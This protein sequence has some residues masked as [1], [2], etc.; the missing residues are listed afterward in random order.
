MTGFDWIQDSLNK[1][2]EQSIWYFNQRY[3]KDKR[4]QKTDFE[5]K[6]D[7]LFWSI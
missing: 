1:A 4:L 2:I 3:G 5:I 7:S 6:N